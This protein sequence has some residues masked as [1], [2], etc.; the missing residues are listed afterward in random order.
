MNQQQQVNG[1]QVTVQTVFD[2]L[3]P[4]E[5]HALVSQGV[6][7]EAAVAFVTSAVQM[8]CTGVTPDG[9]G[10]FQMMLVLPPHLFNAPGRVLD[11]AGKHPI[12]RQIVAALTQLVPMVRFVFKRAGLSAGVQ[13]QLAAEDAK[14]LALGQQIMGGSDGDEA[15]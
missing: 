6:A 15:A 12:D 2:R 4:T 5:A 3:T 14:S 13:E 1:Q 11:A 7:P 9:A 10:V 8:V